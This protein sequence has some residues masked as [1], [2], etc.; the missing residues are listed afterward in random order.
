[1]R[2]PTDEAI[3]DGIT[4]RWNELRGVLSRDP[5]AIEHARGALQRVLNHTPPSGGNN[6]QFRDSALWES[7]FGFA[8][9]K[10]VHF[11][12]N[13]SDF[14]QNRDRSRGLATNLQAEL[15]QAGRTVKIYSTVD[16]FLTALARPLA[17]LNEP[18]ICDAILAAT[19]PW[20]TELI[21]KDDS[22]KQRHELG[23]VSQLTIKGYATP[24]PTAVAVTFEVV[25]NYQR[26]E[27]DENSERQT[28]L[29]SHA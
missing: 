15:E 23:E 9:T 27:A 18:E 19:T 6:E 5:F 25:F 13:D 22:A 28:I 12:T 2:I 11:V 7:V 29:T 14:Y 16:G 26:I 17:V 3:R 1:M 10:L 21:C 24:K 8:G 4:G 20:A